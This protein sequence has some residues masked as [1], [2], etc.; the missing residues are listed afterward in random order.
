MPRIRLHGALPPFYR[1]NR[2]N[3]SISYPDWGLAWRFTETFL[4]VCVRACVRAC[5]CVYIYIY[6][7]HLS[8]FSRSGLG[9]MG[10]NELCPSDLQNLVRGAWCH[11]FLQVMKMRYTVSYNGY[12]HFDFPTVE[13]N[14]YRVRTAIRRNRRGRERKICRLVFI[15]CGLKLRRIEKRICK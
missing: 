3:S 4:C 10:F 9:F 2:N 1:Q 8:R 7:S 12:E 13:G 14:V 6:A 5:V 15:E 11:G